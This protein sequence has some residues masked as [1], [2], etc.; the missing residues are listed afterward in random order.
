MV[1]VPGWY[2][3]QDGTDRTEA[4]L[5]SD[6]HGDVT[7]ERPQRRERHKAG[8]GRDGHHLKTEQL[9]EQLDSIRVETIQA[10]EKNQ[11]LQ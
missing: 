7:L 3:Y 2:K 11:L 9:R 4:L 6:R 10:K 5:Q 8:G 1:Q